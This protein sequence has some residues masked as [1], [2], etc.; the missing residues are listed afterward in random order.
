MK[1]VLLS[2]RVQTIE[3]RSRKFSRMLFLLFVRMVHLGWK[4]SRK[5]LKNIT[6]MLKRCIF[7]WIRRMGGERSE[8]NSQ[9]WYLMATIDMLQKDGQRWK[10]RPQMKYLRDWLNITAMCIHY[11]YF[12]ESVW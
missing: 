12:K 4:N 5:C 11:F 10:T 6:L 3:I 7:S 8:K 1:D 9:V 2:L